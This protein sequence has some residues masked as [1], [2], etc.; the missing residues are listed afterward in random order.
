MILQ[1]KNCYILPQLRKP[2]VPLAFPFFHYIY[3]LSPPSVVSL[4]R[5]LITNSKSL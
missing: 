5:F 4:T 1:F 3:I 2:A